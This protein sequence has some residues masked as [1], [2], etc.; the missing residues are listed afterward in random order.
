MQPTEGLKTLV[1]CDFDGTITDEDVSFMLLDAFANRD[2]R[3]YLTRY[4]EG[5]I[6]VSRFNTEAFITVKED[7]QT[8]DSF[9]TERAKIRPGFYK[10]LG[11]CQ[12]RGFRFVIVSNGMGFYIKTILKTLGVADIEV[13]AAQAIFDPSGIKAS[14]IGPDGTELQDSFKEA[15][16]R[17]FLKSGYR[18]IY[19]GNGASD[20]PSARLAHHVFATGPLLAHCRQ[21]NLKCTPFADLNDV[22]RGMELLA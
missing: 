1:Q 16:I 11:Y 19:I 8:L 5:K 22:I 20:I 6:S 4:Q 9:V 7:K 12:Q 21:A 18:I 13:F 14:Y 2:W 10:L 15:Y 17:H 3:R